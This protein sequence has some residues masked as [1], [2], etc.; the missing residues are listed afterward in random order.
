[1]ENHRAWPIILM[2]NGV[3]G[4]EVANAN[5][6]VRKRA[7]HCMPAISFPTALLPNDQV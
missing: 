5:W 6:G 1:M 3:N 7:C 2:A 4:T